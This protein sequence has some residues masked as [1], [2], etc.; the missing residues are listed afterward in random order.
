M[1]H[2]VIPWPS[3]FKF[4]SDLKSQRTLLLTLSKLVTLALNYVNCVKDNYCNIKINCYLY[5]LFIFYI[6][7]NVMWNIENGLIEVN[8]SYH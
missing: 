8:V 6:I 4:S 3:M 1:P 5:L 7:I 2:S